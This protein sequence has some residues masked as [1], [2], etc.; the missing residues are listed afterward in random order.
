MCCPHRVSDPSRGFDISS[1]NCCCSQTDAQS[2]PVPPG[3]T[4]QAA[5]AFAYRLLHKAVNPPVLMASG[6]I[7]D[8]VVKGQDGQWMFV[9]RK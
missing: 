7:E 3:A 4:T 2:L 1:G 8:R 5:R 9:E 6:L